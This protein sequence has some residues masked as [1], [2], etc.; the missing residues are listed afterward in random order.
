MKKMYKKPITESLP[1]QAMTNI[2]DPSA[3]NSNVQ[4]GAPGRP[5]R[6]PMNIDAPNP[7]LT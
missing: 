5:D 3:P 6:A 1:I 2:C 4:E 7:N